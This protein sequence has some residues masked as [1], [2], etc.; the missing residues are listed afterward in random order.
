MQHVSHLTHHKVTPQMD[1]FSHCCPLLSHVMAITMVNYIHSQSPTHKASTHKLDTSFVTC[2][3]K[4]KESTSTRPAFFSHLSCAPWGCA[5]NS[6]HIVDMLCSPLPLPN[7]IQPDSPLL[8]LLL[9]LEISNA[10]LQWE[11]V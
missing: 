5:E 3:R 11:P 2:L 4:F 8:P 1:G 9:L 10:W 7:F 6:L